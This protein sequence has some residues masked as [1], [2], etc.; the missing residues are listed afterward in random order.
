ML[1][2]YILVFWSLSVSTRLLNCLLAWILFARQILMLI[3]AT[4]VLSHRSVWTRKYRFFSG[5]AVKGPPISQV[6]GIDFA[7]C[8]VSDIVFGDDLHVQ[9]YPFDPGIMCSD[10]L[11]INYS[12]DFDLEY[13]FLLNNIANID[14]TSL[15]PVNCGIEVFIIL[16]IT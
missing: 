3:L 5:L 8:H 13:N 4:A 7:C 6:I 12:T 14:F 9:C 16:M 15:F 1:I 2:W 10:N 11:N